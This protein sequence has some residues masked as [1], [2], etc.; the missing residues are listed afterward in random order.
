MDLYRILRISIYLMVASGAFAV[1]MAE[2]NPSFL[3][4][5]LFFGV[6]AY[7][8][9]D[10]QHVKPARPEYAVAMTVALLFYTFLPLRNAANWEKFPTAAAHFLCLFQTLL[11]FTVYRDLT[12]LVFCGS[13]LLVVIAS[14]VM[15]SDASLLLRMGG[16]VGLLIWTLFIHALWRAR[17]NFNRRL[18]ANPNAT[19]PASHDNRPMTERV[20]WQ[21]L[22]MTA[23]MSAL[24]LTLGFVF[25]F[26]APHLNEDLT[27]WVDWLIRRPH[28]MP[29]DSDGG[30]GTG[31]R[32]K[33]LKGLPE[34]V[35]LA[36]FGHILDDPR[37]ALTVTFSLPP[38][39]FSDKNGRIHLRGF[40][41]SDYQDGVWRSDPTQIKLELKQD[42]TML[43][44]TD[45]S[46]QGRALV[47][48]EIKQTMRNFN[49]V[50]RICLALGAISKLD[51]PAALQDSEGGLRLADGDA[52]MRYEIWSPATLYEDN[53]P[54]N[55]VADHDDLGRYVRRHGFGPNVVEAVRRRALSI[56]T[57]HDT[58]L[59]KVRAIMRHLR[60]S[61]RYR[62]TL[63]ISGAPIEEFLLSPDET[64]RCG[65]CAHFATAFVLLCRLNNIPARLVTGFC[66]R[67]QTA[68]FEEDVREVEFYNSDAHAWGEVFFKDHGW[69][70]FDPTPVAPVEKKIP[71]EEKI[72]AAPPAAP[73]MPFSSR[74]KLG[75]FDRAWNCI[76]TF[77]SRYQQSMYER[78]ENTVRGGLS[79]TGAT[80]T[81]KGA[82]GYLV[83]SL[84]WLMIGG[85]AGWLI[86]R[87]LRQ[88]N[89]RRSGVLPLAW[90]RARAAV[91]FYN[92]LLQMLS[93]RGFVR[94]SNQTPN[95]FAEFV[96]KRGGEA[97]KPVLTVT[98]IFESVRY[99]GKDLSQEDFNR[100]QNML[101]KL[102][103]LTFI[104][105][106]PPAK[107]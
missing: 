50:S 63:R 73:E 79:H 28:L 103:E 99:G 11:F 15:K 22:T 56:I 37:L 75:I 72:T 41:S 30:I 66:A 46:S 77:N 26:S 84:V 27:G 106:G 29:T 32:E 62:Y 59:E 18:I 82:G 36:R 13:S 70:T 54:D 55:A 76:I 85:L 71:V 58:A 6:L 67:L 101:D 97:F 24:C 95:E 10:S 14:G 7:T 68:H 98:E 51:A 69:V 78:V 8:T 92:D 40:V 20:F 42:E 12:L 47:G 45:P 100:L 1:S 21:G 60:D 31:G 2:Q 4:A 65:H 3:L 94:R 34:T 80:L 88:R 35:N 33:I 17:E 43:K 16:C 81:G 96:V 64:K 74:S 23:S 48:P 83:T 61:G 25:F 93:R 9:I 91:A 87:R 86:Q 52:R 107:P 102:R 104:V 49:N 105:T 57:T 90:V 53:L 5:V 89:L 19:P 44:I 39:D 38:T